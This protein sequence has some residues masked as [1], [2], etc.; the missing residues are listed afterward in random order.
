[1]RL[2]MLSGN[3]ESLSLDARTKH[4]PIWNVQ[5]DW[6]IQRHVGSL[7]AGIQK[8]LAVVCMDY[9]Q[10]GEFSRLIADASADHPVSIVLPNGKRGIARMLG[11]ASLHDPPHS[12]ISSR[13]TSFIRYSRVR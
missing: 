6:S 12:A 4:S 11:S 3:L 7:V 2:S 5:G 8:D 10:I 1:M 13:R 9:T